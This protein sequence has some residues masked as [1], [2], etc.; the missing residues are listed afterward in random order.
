[1]QKSGFSNMTPEE[2]KANGRKGGLASVKKRREKKAM[3]ENLEALLSM[4]LK[5]GKLAD[6]ETIKNFAALNGKNVS[7]QDAILIKQ[8]QKAMKGDT[9]A[10]E[11]IRDLSGNKPGSSLDIKSNGQIV[12]ID[13]IE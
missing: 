5:S 7:V 13:D 2:R 11:F 9:R 4:S 10:A 8:I 6:V 3:K 1:M 12:I